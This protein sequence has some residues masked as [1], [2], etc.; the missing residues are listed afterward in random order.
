MRLQHIAPL[1][2]SHGLSDK[3]A[4][5]ECLSQNGYGILVSVLCV[6]NAFIVFKFKMKYSMEFNSRGVQSAV[7]GTIPGM[8]IT[9]RNM[10]V[11]NKVTENHYELRYRCK[12]FDN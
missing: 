10:Y 5:V 2:H 7:S 11:M 4:R 12:S 3:Y 1:C 9:V 8:K 6:L